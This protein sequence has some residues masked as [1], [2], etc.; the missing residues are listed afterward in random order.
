VQL[1]PQ[2]IISQAIGRKQV[3]SWRTPQGAA[4]LLPREDRIRAMLESFYALTDPTRPGTADQVRVEVLNGAGCYQAEQLAAVALRLRG[5]QVASTGQA[6]LQDYAQTQ[7]RVHSGAL[8]FGEEVAKELGVPLTAI[9]D[10]TTS[11]E[12]AHPSNSI[13]IRVILGTDYG[14][15]QP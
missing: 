6:D 14:S 1:K 3:K 7:I 5:F 4:V 9:Q 11:G 13:D 15:C 8:A 10:L 12:E 2:H